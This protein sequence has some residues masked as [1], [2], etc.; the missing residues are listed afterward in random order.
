[1][2]RHL[3]AGLITGSLVLTALVACNTG[4]RDPIIGEPINPDIQQVRLG[5]TIIDFNA[6]NLVHMD[7]SGRVRIDVN[8]QVNL[9]RVRETIALNLQVF[10]EDGSVMQLTGY[11]ANTY[12]NYNLVDRDLG[13]IDWIPIDGALDGLRPGVRYRMRISSFYMQVGDKDPDGVALSD[14]E[15]DLIPLS[16]ARL[17][18]DTALESDGLI[19]RITLGTVGVDRRDN[20]YTLVP[21]DATTTVQ[22]DLATSIDPA[23]FQ[24]GL[25]YELVINNLTDGRSFNFSKADLDANGEFSFPNPNNSLI[26]WTKTSPGG[27]AQFHSTAFGG[28]I[29]VSDVGDQLELR[30]DRVSGLRSD[31]ARLTLRDRAFRIL[32]TFGTAADG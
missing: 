16:L 17:P 19:N 22:V 32:H 2:P 10:G 11:D 26:V 6:N 30:F 14:E 5:N 25:Q 1:M 29:D 7:G 18:F 21:L 27:L 12:G 31:G 9:D 3:L 24:N 13:I 20:E 23:T 28:I 4:P 8:Q 15:F